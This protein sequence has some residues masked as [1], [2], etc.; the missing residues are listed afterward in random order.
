[1]R[2]RAVSAPPVPARRYHT[3]AR[4]ETMLQ[5]RIFVAFG[6]RGW[7]AMGQTRKGSNRALVVRFSLVHCHSPLDLSAGIKEP[8]RSTEGGK[9]PPTPTV[10]PAGFDEAT[11]AGAPRSGDP[12]P[13]PQG[14]TGRPT[15]VM[16]T[17]LV[18]ACHEK[19]LGTHRRNSSAGFRLL[20]SDTFR[21]V[22]PGGVSPIKSDTGSFRPMME[23][24]MMRSHRPE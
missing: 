13:T 15:C 20:S 9:E 14:C 19:L 1:V 2:R 21:M 24:I 17:R 18:V 12:Q 23:I 5:R 10:T 8:G 4:Q 3:A 6:R 16:N 7:S 22:R 11:P